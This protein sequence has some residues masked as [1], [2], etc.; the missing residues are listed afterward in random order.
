MVNIVLK[1]NLQWAGH[2]KKKA[3]TCFQDSI[4]NEQESKQNIQTYNNQIMP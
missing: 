4:M 3:D 1:Y 2:S